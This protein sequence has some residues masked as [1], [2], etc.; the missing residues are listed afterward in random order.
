MRQ[1]GKFDKATFDEYNAALVQLSDE[2]VRE[3]YACFM[4]VY[5]DEAS[6]EVLLLPP[7]NL[8]CHPLYRPPAR[9]CT[10]P[11]QIIPL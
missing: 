1:D 5:V 11:Y 9:C 10:K 8:T 6:D 4:Q 2:H 3:M 7:H